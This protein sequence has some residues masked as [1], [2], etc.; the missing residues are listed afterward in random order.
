MS[1]VSSTKSWLQAGRA[2]ALSADVTSA[3]SLK[4]AVR[5]TLDRFGRI[6]IL[7]NN[8]GIARDQLLMPH[9]GRGVGTPSSLPT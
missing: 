6:D 7:V 4:A 2:E 3:D 9:E 5:A 8:A 1:G